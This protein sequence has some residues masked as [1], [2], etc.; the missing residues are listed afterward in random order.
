MRSLTPLLMLA[1]L[2]CDCGGPPPPGDAGPIGD[3]RLNELMARN[4]TTHP[5]EG[6]AFP[7]W[8]E[9]V[10]IGDE[11]IDLG[12]YALSDDL[13]RPE[14]FVF[15]EGTELG[16]GGFVVVFADKDVDE[17]PLHADFRLSGDGESVVLTDPDGVTVD[18]V[19]FGP[20]RVDVSIG[21]FP[22][23]EG[24]FTTMSAPTPGAANAPPGTPD[25]GPIVLPDGGVLPP[26]VETLR[27]NEVLALP[28]VPTNDR[29]NN[30]ITEG[31]VELFNTGPETVDLGL[32]QINGWPIHPQLAELGPFARLLVFA[33]NDPEG[34]VDHAAFTLGDTGTV[35]LTAP[36]GSVL[37][38]LSYGPS[39]VGVSEC[40]SGTVQLRC[41]P[42]PGAD[43]TPLP[44]AG[45]QNS[46]AGAPVDGG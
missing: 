44:D 7:D 33:T 41:E 27:V 18:T 23:G 36:D 30:P 17:G 14:K 39:E 37:D 10:N 6:G 13:L 16:G 21:R 46:D 32:H 11:A 5:D 26:G 2:G 20:Q 24:D 22:D 35:T 34:G 15:A 8:I 19:T 4:D 42:T 29:A 25:G 9:L 40:I 31:W 28:A 1:L 43:N 45:P 3:L 38:E 12:G